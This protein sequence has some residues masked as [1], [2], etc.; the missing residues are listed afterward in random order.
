MGRLVGLLASVTLLGGCEGAAGI[1]GPPGPSG[2]DGGSCSV[3]DTTGGATIACDDGSTVQI[4]DGEPGAQGDPGPAGEDPRFGTDT[5][6]AAAGRGG[7]CVLGQVWLVAGAVAS[8]TP[9]EGQLLAISANDALFS[10][11]GTTYGGDGRTTFG[12]PDLRDA[13]PNG[14]TYV[15]CTSGLYPSRD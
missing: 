13:A 4:L 8:G 12:L 9:A 1:E 2:Q 11:L 5:E 10:L 6:R 7:E 3:S 15:I 14:L